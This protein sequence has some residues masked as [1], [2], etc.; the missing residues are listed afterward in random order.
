MVIALLRKIVHREGL[1]FLHE[2]KKRQAAVVQGFSLR[3]RQQSRITPE[4]EWEEAYALVSLR[5][6]QTSFRVLFYS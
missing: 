5:A 6:S 3:M 4:K 2:H 1:C